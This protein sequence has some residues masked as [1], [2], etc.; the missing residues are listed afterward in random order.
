ML[1]F[2]NHVKGLGLSDGQ[3]NSF[4]DFYFVKIPQSV[5][6]YKEWTGRGRGSGSM[7]TNEEAAVA[8]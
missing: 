6:L 5:L 4:P 3:S 7:E 8:R 1:G 2:V